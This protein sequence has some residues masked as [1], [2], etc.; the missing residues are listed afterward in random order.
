ME[1]SAAKMDD[2]LEKLIDQYGL[3]AVL[4]SIARIC[5]EKADH[6]R[7]SY[8]DDDLAEVWDEAGEAL[9]DLDICGEL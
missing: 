7:S 2:K 6:I 1:I 5:A 3:N 9:N 8:S 4:E